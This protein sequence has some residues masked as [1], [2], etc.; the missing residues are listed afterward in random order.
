[1]SMTDG[2]TADLERQATISPGEQAAMPYV[3]RTLANPVPLGLLS[4]GTNI[5]MI[6]LIGLQPRGARAS[7]ILVPDLIFF[8]GSSQFFAGIIAY[9]GGNIYPATLFTAFGAFNLAY[10]MIFLP[11]SGVLAAYTDA[12]TGAL[13]PEF[14]QAVAMFLWGWFIVAMIFT[15]ATIRVTWVLLMALIFVDLTLLLLAIGHMLGE[16]SCLKAGCA[17]GFAAGFFAFWE[18]ASGLW[19]NGM[20][21]INLPVGSLKKH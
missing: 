20:T 2:K 4:F 9:I 21:P 19:G 7:N 14:D 6:S 13:L 12:S 3:P 10:G 17:T 11:A 1:M 16:Q 8:G 15:V 18:G 5:F